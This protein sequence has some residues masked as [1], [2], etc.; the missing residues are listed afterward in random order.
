MI[1]QT[2]VATYGHIRYSIA[3]TVSNSDVL[4][5]SVLHYGKAWTHHFTIASGKLPH[6]TGR[7]SNQ[8][9]AII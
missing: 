8:W 1:P 2:M 4:T 9:L 3:C 6:W 7:L 5:H